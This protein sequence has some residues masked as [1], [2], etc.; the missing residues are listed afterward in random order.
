MAK[1]SASAS[2]DQ[3]AI[4]IQLEEYRA[5]YAIALFRMSSLERRVPL[6]VAAII[7]LLASILALTPSNQIAVLMMIPL[8]LVWHLATTINHAR[9]FEDVLRRIDEIER[10]VNAIADQDL[11]LFQSSHPSRGKHVG[12]RTGHESVRAV[13]AG[14]M[15]TLLA[16]L[17]LFWG[18]AD[19]DLLLTAYYGVCL[20]AV[21]AYATLRVHRLTRYRYDKRR[22]SNAQTN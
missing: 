16:S 5:L 1:E 13:F 21:G 7:A 22:I 14:S 12:G 8:G 11:L 10:E 4:S 9:S 19:Y 2:S 18:A 6:G 17:W 20:M 15:L 3:S